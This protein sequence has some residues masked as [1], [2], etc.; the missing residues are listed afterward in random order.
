M[1]RLDD[2]EAFL[3]VVEEGSLTAAARHLRRSLQ[4]I[5]RSLTTL[6]RGGG[7]GARHTTRRSHPTEAARPLSAAKAGVHRDQGMP[8]SKHAAGSGRR[9]A[10][11]KLAA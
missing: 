6:E 10:I 4:S 11:P 1:D 8:G 9:R 7:P 5:T 2:I 3:A